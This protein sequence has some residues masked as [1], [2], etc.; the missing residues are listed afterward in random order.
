MSW[1]F[2]LAAEADS[3]EQPSSDG[4]PSAPWKSN[5][6]V[7]KLSCGARG[8]VCCR[9]SRSGTTSEPSQKETA[10]SAESSVAYA[11]SAVRSLSRAGFHASRSRLPGEDS[12]KPTTVT[13]GLKQS[14]SYAKWDPNSS[15]WKTYQLSLL[16]NTSESLS[17]SFPKAGIAWRGRLYRLRSL[18]RPI[19]E[20]VSG[21]S[22]WPTPRSHEAGDY[23]YDKGDKAKPRPTLSGAAKMFP[24]PNVPN[25]GRSVRKD[26]VWKGSSAY[27]PETGQ[28]IQV[29]LEHHVRMWPTP[30]AT[31][32]SKAPKYYAGGN[33][34]L[35]HAVKVWPTPKSSPSG[36]DYARAGR[37][38]A[39]GD[40]LAT[41]VA[42]DLWPT[43]TSSDAKGRGKKYAQ[44]GTPLS[45]A[46]K[47]WPTPSARDWKS[48]NASP[49][50]MKKNA[51]PLNETVTRGAGGALNPMWVEWLMG[52]P[53]G[54][55]ALE[56]LEMDKYQRWLEQHG[57]F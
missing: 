54:W 52:W 56:P 32:G 23:T 41:A 14:E 9:C 13:Y 7:G 16:T 46:A 26:A 10:R 17:G 19:V 44:G 34:S 31:D 40:D 11:A 28:K 36:P 15:G 1:H 45:C 50:T 30:T 18:E 20:I 37:E 8:T 49:E 35:P 33:P 55:T 12:E 43:P 53:L 48:S 5:P 27:D 57:N 29:G 24:T 25:G 22:E 4:P 21:S 39:G 51:R 47:T 42:R 6:T 38:G 3:S 2:T